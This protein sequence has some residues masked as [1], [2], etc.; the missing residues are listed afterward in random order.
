MITL[1]CPWERAVVKLF[2]V[3]GII[4]SVVYVIDMMHIAS[5]RNSIALINAVTW[6][7]GY[8]LVILLALLITASHPFRLVTKPTQ[9]AL[10]ARFTL[11]IWLVSA[12][13]ALLGVL[14]I[15]LLYLGL[16]PT[17]LH[18]IAIGIHI[19]WL[20]PAGPG[21]VIGVLL[22][23][24]QDKELFDS[25]VGIETRSLKHNAH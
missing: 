18:D 7:S 5:L 14:V 3:V 6:A 1:P 2:A 22:F 21:S 25:Q 9:S 13:A 8:G 16:I 11:A 20:Y 23:I 12:S 4:M 15:P 19:Y 24:S 10:T 17:S